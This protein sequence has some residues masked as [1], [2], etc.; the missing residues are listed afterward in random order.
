MEQL[1]FPFFDG[2][3]DYCQ[4]H[5]GCN[6]YAVY[7]LEWISL[8]QHGKNPIVIREIDVCPKHLTGNVN[9]YDNVGYADMVTDADTNKKE[10]PEVL[11][12]A[13]RSYEDG[14]L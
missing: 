4:D 6:N 9:Y 7:T 13:I 14:C 11:E 3:N 10:F 8:N 5:A 1:N 12:R 2:K